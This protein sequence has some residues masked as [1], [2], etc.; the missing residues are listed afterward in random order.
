MFQISLVVIVILLNVNKLFYHNLSY[1][2]KSNHII[3][4]QIISH[5]IKRVVWLIRLYDK[6]NLNSPN[7]G[8][9][10]LRLFQDFKFTRYHDNGQDGGK[11]DSFRHRPFLPPAN[12]PGTDSY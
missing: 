2:T 10:W 5:H 9:V 6:K 7:T 12:N 4:Y 8:L 1:R 11:V 3:S